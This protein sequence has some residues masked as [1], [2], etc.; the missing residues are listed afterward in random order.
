MTSQRLHQSHIEKFHFRAESDSFAYK[1]FVHLMRLLKRE[2]I[3]SMNENVGAAS[4]LISFMC[5]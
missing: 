4:H 3:K 1:C 5:T 2:Q